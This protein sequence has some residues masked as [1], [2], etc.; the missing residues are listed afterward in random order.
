MKISILASIW[1]HNLGDELIL[2][3]EIQL[4]QQEFGLNTTFRVFT[5]DMKSPFIEADYIE[6]QEY[7]PIA[8]KD[9]KNIFRN[10]KNYFGFIKTLLW[11]DIVVIWWWGI[12]Y[13][14]E[15][16]STKSPLNQWLFRTKISHLL[17]K[18]IYFYGISIDIKQTENL[19]KIRSIFSGAYKVTVR[20]AHSQDVLSK[21][22]IDSQVIDDPVMYDNPSFD[23]PVTSGKCLQ[24]LDSKNFDLRD[25]SGIDFNG[26]TVWFAL[27]KWYFSKSGSDSIE[28]AMI[29]ELL[30]YIEKQGWKIVLL[31]HSFH[32]TDIQANDYEFLKQ[33]LLSSTGV[34]YSNRN[35]SQSMQETYIHYTNNKLDIVFAQRLH[36]MILSEVYQ[37]PYIALSYSKKTH[38]Q[39]KKLSK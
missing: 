10:I 1:A 22:W 39:L 15:K 32:P 38:E 23:A 36:S 16:Q 30:N 5:Y 3:N 8:I 19:E 17:R 14:T 6:Y 13:D 9:P 35:I 12:F 33:F 11:S 27:R 34:K 18:K 29:H 28:K 20:N 21:L 24:I 37:I 7:F 4:L 2:K 26:K 25:I 31:P